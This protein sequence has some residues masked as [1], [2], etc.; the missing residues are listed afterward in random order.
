[1]NKLL[2]LLLL[3]QPVKF[4]ILCNLMPLYPDGTPLKMTLKCLVW[5]FFV[6][7]LQQIIIDGNKGRGEGGMESGREG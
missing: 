1:M 6:P 7:A 2:S 4:F 3:Q 5:L